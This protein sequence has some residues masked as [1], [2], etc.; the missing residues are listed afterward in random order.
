MFKPEAK[1]CRM[2]KD[3]L[4]DVTYLRQKSRYTS[5]RWSANSRSSGRVRPNG[6]S[7]LKVRN[8]FVGAANG[9]EF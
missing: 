1:Q 3:R 6:S 5:D 7:V 9:V 8:V 4:W 2:V